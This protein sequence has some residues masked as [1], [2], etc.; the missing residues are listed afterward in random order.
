MPIFLPASTANPPAA[1]SA[2][3]PDGILTATLYENGTHLYADFSAVAG[4]W[5]KVRFTRGDT[6]VRS[7]ND[8][9]APYGQAHAYDFE[10]PL[11]QAAT[12]IA[13]P[14]DTLG[15]LGTPSQ[16]VTIYLPGLPEFDTDH[17]C[18]LKS[19]LQPDLSMRLE[20]QA[21]DPET[22][23]DGRDQLTQ[24]PGSDLPAGAWDIPVQPAQS[25]TFKTY[26]LD[27]YKA[28]VELLKAG[29]L[30][31][32]TDALFGIDDFYAL[33][34]S[35]HT[36][37]QV[38]AY[39]PRRLI[40]VGLQPCPRPDPYGAPLI[41]PNRTWDLVAENVSSWNALTGAYATWSDMVGPL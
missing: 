19:V 18:W 28:L 33:R 2:T 41:I 36:A 5:M 31:V 8:A 11:G 37:Y 15:N 3:S 32:Q 24:I 21:P 14:I 4:D 12:W 7:G 23:Q 39:D 20:M 29:P 10:A 27:E 6:L 38:G 9:W 26:T 1:V 40:T 34:Q 17:D 16:A 30:L 13:T 22:E 35:V 25:F